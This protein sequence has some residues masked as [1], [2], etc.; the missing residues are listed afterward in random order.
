[1]VLTPTV[2]PSLEAILIYYISL[3][4]ENSNHV[5]KV[6]QKDENPAWHAG[7]GGVFVC[8]KYVYSGSI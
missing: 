5:L 4:R 2:P 8:V 1:M 6:T 3:F 7:S